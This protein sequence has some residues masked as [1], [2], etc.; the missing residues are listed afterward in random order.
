MLRRI[1]TCGHLT[2]IVVGE[3]QLRGRLRWGIGNLVAGGYL[4]SDTHKRVFVYEVSIIVYELLK[5]AVRSLILVWEA[6][7][8]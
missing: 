2:S 6:D 5:F 4:L 1:T 8:T 7:T 3:V